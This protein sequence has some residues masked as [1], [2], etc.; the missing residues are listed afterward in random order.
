MGRQTGTWVVTSACIRIPFFYSSTARAPLTKNPPLLDTSTVINSINL[1][2][3]QYHYFDFYH[4]YLNPYL[5]VFFDRA[6]TT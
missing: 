3:F 2:I 5:L 6:G 4:Y 1:I